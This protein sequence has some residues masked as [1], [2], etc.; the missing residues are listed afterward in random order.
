MHSVTII[1]RMLEFYPRLFRAPPPPP[2]LPPPTSAPPPPP[3]HPLSHPHPN[4]PF[5]H[6]PGPAQVRK[7]I[8]EIN[9]IIAFIRRVSFKRQ[10]SQRGYIYV[11]CTAGFLVYLFMNDF[12]SWCLLLLQF[13]DVS[14]LAW[15]CDECTWHH[16]A[17]PVQLYWHI[18]INPNT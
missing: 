6:L 13:N 16:Q 15:M 7:D 10:T 5:P 4:P 18:A 14:W 17:F 9:F 8:R 12:L 1:S 2:A 11:I 3:A